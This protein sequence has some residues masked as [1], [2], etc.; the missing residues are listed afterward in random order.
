M[1]G[2]NLLYNLCL[3]E[4]I[5]DIDLAD[6]YHTQMG[7]WAEEVTLRM[8]ELQLW[9]R[10]AFWR[11]LSGAG[12]RIAIGTKVFVEHW[13]ELIIDR[14]RASAIADD[15]SAR[16]LIAQRE[17]QLKGPLA[18]IFNPRARELWSGAAGTVRLT[19]RW[20]NAQRIARD[21]LEALERPD[22]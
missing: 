4:L 11:C 7:A 3:A 22:A 1:H 5:N 6:D 13:W 9:D 20:S 8:G 2:A 10:A 17:R 21:I 15:E 18:R 12:A 16:R 14:R 19:Y